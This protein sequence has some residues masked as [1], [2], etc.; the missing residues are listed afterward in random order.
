MV[1]GVFFCWLLCLRDFCLP[2]IVF[3]ACVS[4]VVFCEFVVQCF[5]TSSLLCVLL[6]VVV[7]YVL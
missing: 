1:I 3:G 4:S 2:V 5:L 6:V 7:V